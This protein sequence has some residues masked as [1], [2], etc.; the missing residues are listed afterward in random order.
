MTYDS[1]VIMCIHWKAI[2]SDESRNQLLVPELKAL[3]T[4]NWPCKRMLISLRNYITLPFV[5]S[6][7]MS[8]RN[9]QYILETIR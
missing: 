6:T 2:P 1:P 5:G 7:D 9:R 4:G 8:T 3:F